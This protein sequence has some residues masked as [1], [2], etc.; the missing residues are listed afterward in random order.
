LGLEIAYGLPPE[1]A[2]DWQNDLQR[3]RDAHAHPERDD[4]FADEEE[5]EKEIQAEAV[6]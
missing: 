1:A 5:I 3:W 2:P 6:S 4:D